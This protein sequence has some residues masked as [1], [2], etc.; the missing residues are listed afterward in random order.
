VI[1]GKLVPNYGIVQGK[2]MVGKGA[3][4]REQ[5]Q[6]R[7]HGPKRVPYWSLRGRNLNLL[8]TRGLPQIYGSDTLAN[9]NQPLAAQVAGLGRQGYELAI[10]YVLR[11]ME[12]AG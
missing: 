8:G 7:D 10:A 5:V 12:K 6:E 9:I 4:A 3:S 1:S 11:Q 2:G